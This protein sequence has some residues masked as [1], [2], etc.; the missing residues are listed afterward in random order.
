MNIKNIE[1]ANKRRECLIYESTEGGVKIIHIH[2]KKRDQE[3]SINDYSYNISRVDTCEYIC[4]CGNNYVKSVRQITDFTG[5]SCN[6]CLQKNRCKKLGIKYWDKKTLWDY[7][8]K[9]IILWNIAQK[10]RKGNWTV[11][12][13]KWF[14][15]YH[16]NYTGALIHKKVRWQDNLKK[17]GCD[18]RRQ[19]NITENELFEEIFDIYKSKG[20]GELTRSNL[21]KY[22]NIYKIVVIKSFIKKTARLGN[23]D[24][25]NENIC[26]K[27]QE[28][29]PEKCEN[30]LLERKEYLKLNFPRE[31]DTF[32]ELCE[33]HIKPIL[34]LLF[35]HE[36]LNGILLTQETFTESNNCAIVNAWKDIFHKT[37]YD[38][39]E[40][41]G[42]VL[43]SPNH[44]LSYSRIICDSQLELR[45]YNFL[46]LRDIEVKP[47]EHYKGELKSLWDDGRFYSPILKKIVIIEIFGLQT[48]EYKKKMAIKKDYHAK[49]TDDSTVLLS[50]DNTEKYNLL[51][52][53]TLIEIF[54]P[55]I[56][57]IQPKILSDEFVLEFSKYDPSKEFFEESKKLKENSPDGFFPNYSELSCSMQNKLHVYGNG[58]TDIRA[59]LGENL[60]EAEKA[61]Q[62]R[63]QEK[64]TKTISLR[65][66]EQRQ[67]I[68]NKMLK[69]RE[70]WTDE[71]RENWRNNISKTRIENGRSKGKNNPMYGRS[72]KGEKHPPKI[73]YKDKY[74]PNFLKFM[75]S[76]HSKHNL[77]DIIIS[78]VM[79]YKY[80]KEKK[81]SSQRPWHN[82]GPYNPWKET[83]FK[84]FVLDAIK[85]GADKKMEWT[86][87]HDWI[88]K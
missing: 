15:T 35:A 38:I 12:S 16:S 86:G 67:E 65:T 29:Y 76:L 83:K 64:R 37:I 74:I 39:R 75:L 43:L 5:F 2:S 30:I 57:L 24:F 45:V 48:D 66:D 31:C 60:E 23:Q 85:Y 22:K 28:L 9:Y 62:R 55:Y 19:K 11:P 21:D 54:K 81:I 4:K 1:Y 69:T 8:C 84:G 77:K 13:Y 44:Y 25:P 26:K 72:R 17:F 3:I 47:H 51:K 36:Q 7:F 40:Y 79:W 56:G 68:T 82:P 80:A 70:K 50:I 78:E 88:L 73:N 42:L 46:Y 10:N 61:K 18:N 6:V 32:E 71:E 27:L 33:I 52:E 34:P 63:Q 41:F 20:I 14:Q 59:K 87:I 58:I 53:N 49:N